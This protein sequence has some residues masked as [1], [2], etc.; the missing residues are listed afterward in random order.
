MN[1]DRFAGEAIYLDTNIVIF[2]IEPREPW[3]KVLLALFEAFDRG[4]IRAITSEL[5]IAEALAQPIAVGNEDLIS[6]YRELFASDSSVE[7]VPIDR[8]T[9]MRA[10]EIRGRLKLKLVD[11]IHIATARLASCDHFL[12]Q[13]ARLRRALADELHWLQLS[14][15]P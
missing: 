5:T 12:T 4:S 6:K 1:W 2:A 11:A 15:E 3:F 7:T 10:A 9:L 8:A 13:D 14:G